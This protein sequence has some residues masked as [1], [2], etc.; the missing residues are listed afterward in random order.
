MTGTEIL[1]LTGEQ[2][3]SLIAER[4]GTSVIERWT[5]HRAMKFYEGF[6]V[7]FSEEVRG[8]CSSEV[9]NQTLQKI[10]SDE[11]RTE[12]LFDAYRSVTLAKSKTIGP[13]IIG[14]LTAAIVIEGRC[15]TEE[16]E[17][18]FSAAEH[19]SD[20]DLHEFVA[21]YSKCSS[22]AL[23]ER[24]G[25]KPYREGEA[26]VVPWGKEERDSAWPSSREAEIDTTP[27]DL[28]EALGSWAARMG[29]IG[30]I[31]SKTTHR[32][33][34]YKEDDERHI[35]QDGVLTIYSFII[36]FHA[37]C[38]GLAALAIRAAAIKDSSS[39][40]VLHP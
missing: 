10:L 26:I 21:C 8:G 35:D 12:I 6:L 9:V 1:V 13:R 19:L 34:E 39:S 3:G 23:K 32:E 24:T 40:G 5:R 4:F 38:K 36:T 17:L 37:T 25:R 14:L 27:I 33:V 28:G 20:G 7:M 18:I 31:S 15:A 22:E 30:L 11:T 29:R 16:E 2:L